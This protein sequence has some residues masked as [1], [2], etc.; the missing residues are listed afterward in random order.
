[1]ANN[2]PDWGAGFLALGQS[3]GQLNEQKRLEEERKL[4]RQQQLDDEQRKRDQA[5]ADAYFLHGQPISQG[6]IGQDATGVVPGDPVAALSPAPLPDYTAQSNSSSIQLSSPMDNVSGI[7]RIVAQRV[8]NTIPVPAAALGL[9]LPEPFTGPAVRNVT[10][11]LDPNVV[12]GG[13]SVPYAPWM[14]G[15]APDAASEI[16]T[17]MN[18]I[19]KPSNKPALYT[20][21]DPVT[22]VP[23]T[24]TYED[25]LQYTR[26]DKPSKAD[27]G[28]YYVTTGDPNIPPTFY[29]D[30]PSMLDGTLSPVGAF[31][32]KPL[33]R[34]S[35]TEAGSGL[36][37]TRVERRAEDVTN[38]L[39]GDP[40]KQLTSKGILRDT[41]LGGTAVSGT[42]FTG[43]YSPELARGVQQAV[44]D[45]I[46]TGRWPIN[47]PTEALGAAVMRDVAPQYVDPMLPAGAQF[48]PGDPT[49]TLDDR[50][51]V[52]GAGKKW[53]WDNVPRVTG[54]PNDR[55]MKPMEFARE[56]LIPEINK[57]DDAGTAWSALVKA[58]NQYGLS[59]DDLKPLLDKKKF[60]KFIGIAASAPAET[61]AAPAGGAVERKQV[62]GKWY[63]K[64]AD[65]WYAE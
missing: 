45:S 7:P 36:D 8:R 40:M 27:N 56:Y 11:E 33:M 34:Y 64:K 55:K 41:R 6:Y 42:D 62:G 61:P 1:M 65:G 30:S 4:L 17:R 28:G 13:K 59:L 25:F 9:N 14:Q 20:W 46:Y 57:A 35:P 63:V 24:T 31:N 15:M 29:A 16:Y 51:V 26:P 5:I 44:T 47:S 38:T 37:P 50:F 10:P 23:V 22:G 2:R 12:L 43:L 18:P 60:A 52:P 53:W 39:L 49:T 19:Q 48:M 58:A 32:G 3:L 21:T 54:A